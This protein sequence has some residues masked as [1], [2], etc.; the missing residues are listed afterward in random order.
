MNIKLVCIATLMFFINYIMLAQE[1]SCNGTISHNEYLKLKENRDSILN[2]LKIN[3][4]KKY[5][6]LISEAQVNSG[7]RTGCALTYYVFRTHLNNSS[8]SPD[9]TAATQATIESEYQT[10]PNGYYVSNF[11]MTQSASYHDLVSIVGSAYDAGTN[12]LTLVGANGAMANFGNYLYNNG[13]GGYSFYILMVPSNVNLVYNGTNVT[14]IATTGQIGVFCAFGPTD[15]GI[16]ISK[17]AYQGVLIHEIGH[18]TGL[19]HNGDASN[20]MNPAP[21]AATSFTSYDKDN[22]SIQFELCYTEGYVAEPCL[23]NSPAPI[24][25]KEFMASAL[26]STTHLSWTTASETNNAYFTVERSGD[27]KDFNEIGVLPGAGNSTSERQ[28]S[29]TDEQPINGINYYRIRQTDFDGQYSY[30]PVESVRFS[31]ASADIDFISPNPVPRF[32]SITLNEQDDMSAVRI[33]NSQGMELSFRREDKNIY[34]D[35]APGIYYLISHSGSK[36]FRFV[37]ME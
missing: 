18:L 25:M 7:N 23:S 28:Y 20:Y 2:E 16:I 3:N 1:H 9:I 4:P 8:F 26:G 30:S 19:G 22:L 6:Q 35:Y 31:I 17:S 34:I 5:R 14:A 29:F 32:S 10:E 12:T 13:P 36:T 15:T 21:G 33:F 27:G 37:V 11:T 24:L